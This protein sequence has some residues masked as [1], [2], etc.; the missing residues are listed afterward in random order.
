MSFN[1]FIWMK[2]IFSKSIHF[3]INWLLLVVHNN[4]EPKINQLMLGHFDILIKLYDIVFNVF[5]FQICEV[6][7]LVIIQN[8]A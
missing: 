6:Y 1:I 5:F 7:G 4:V 8:R 2:F 3:I